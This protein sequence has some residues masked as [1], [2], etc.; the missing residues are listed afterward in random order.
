MDSSPPAVR[1]ATTADLPAM[2][3]M[4][5][6]LVGFH[7]TVDP[8]RFFLPDGVEEGYRWW[9][10]KELPNEDAILL[11]ACDGDD[12]VGYLYGRIE[13]RDWNMLL[14]RHAALHDVF[15]ADSA[16]KRRVGGAL[17][18]AFCA[19]VKERGVPR[20]VLHTAASNTPAQAL[21]AK[22][23]FRVTML[24]MTREI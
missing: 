10:G 7:H 11:V 23:G 19:V 2:A 4:A 5:A 22:L 24:E 17:V 8:Q 18:D 16:R 21:F 13:A 20:V 6:S 3:Q 9:F 12:V 14:D 15:V 1:R